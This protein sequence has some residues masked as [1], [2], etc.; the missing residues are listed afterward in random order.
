MARMGEATRCD[1]AFVRDAKS[2]TVQIRFQAPKKLA[3]K[4]NEVGLF[5]DDFERL[6]AAINSPGWIIISAPPGEG[7]ST[8][9]FAVLMHADRVTKDWVALA[10]YSETE[11]TIE[12]IEL[13]VYDSRKGQRPLDILRSILLKQP[14]V[15]VVPT[16]HDPDSIAAFVEQVNDEHRT[17]FTRAVANSASAALL[18]AL[19][20]APDRQAF[21]KALT[22]VTSQRLARR[23]CDKCKQPMPVTPD[24]IRKLGGDPQKPPTIYKPYSPPDPPPVDSKGKPI[25]IVPCSRCAGV[26][27]LG[28]IAL[29]ELLTVDEPLRKVLL[30]KPDEA[31]LTN[32]GLVKRGR[33]AMQQG[34]RHVLAGTTSLAE[35]Q[36]VFKPAK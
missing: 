7:L 10:D 22:L 34:F 28:R 19:R 23:L 13:N 2:E 36:R 27:Y 32:V 25:E 35:I 5:P 4:A 8:T 31:T 18:E 3:L 1:L 26:G 14:E 17:T 11:T 30:Q 24:L 21:I 9:W 6:T 33:S 16:L 12:N 29:V 20:R 15:F